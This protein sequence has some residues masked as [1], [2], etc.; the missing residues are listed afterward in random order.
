MVKSIEKYDFMLQL[1]RINRVQS[2]LFM[3][4]I[5]IILKIRNWVRISTNILH[6]LH[7]LTKRKSQM[8]KKNH[9]HIVE[10]R[11][12]ERSRRECELSRRQNVSEALKDC[13]FSLTF[14]LFEIRSVVWFIHLTP[15]YHSH[16][17]LTIY[18][19]RNLCFSI[20]VSFF[21]I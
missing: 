13:F 2:M 15:F 20:F 14:P 8:E 3:R 16:V 10:E 18:G 9:S 21:V 11:E 6:A 12:S 17:A 7:S 1:Q 19:A 4:Q 5:R